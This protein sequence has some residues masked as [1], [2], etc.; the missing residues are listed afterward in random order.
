MTGG[1]GEDTPVEWREAETFAEHLLR[2]GVPSG[3][4]LAQ[5]TATNTAASGT[6]NGQDLGAV[7]D[8]ESRS[9]HIHAEKAS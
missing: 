2:S 3:A 9:E 6:D 7:I 8:D 1:I 5:N 4:I